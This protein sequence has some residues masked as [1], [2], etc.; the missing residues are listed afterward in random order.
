[1][2]RSRVGSGEEIQRSRKALTIISNQ[3]GVMSTQNSAKAIEIKIN[4]ITESPQP[5]ITKIE[6]VQIE[7]SLGNSLV[8]NNPI[9]NIIVDDVAVFN[10]E[11]DVSQEF[12]FDQDTSIDNENNETDVQETIE[13]NHET[14]EI[15]E[16]VE[17]IEEID[18]KNGKDKKKEEE[19]IEKPLPS[20]RKPT[21]ASNS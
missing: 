17:E 20:Y 14:E 8:L 19:E 6:E 11:N 18:G 5:T 2:N 13:E 4:V 10:D 12:S 15:T 21:V 16:N 3:T 7:E 9:Q 1:M